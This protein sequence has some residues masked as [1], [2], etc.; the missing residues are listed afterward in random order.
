VAEAKC[1]NC[2]RDLQVTSQNSLLRTYDAIVTWN[3]LVGG[4][5]CLTAPRAVLSEINKKLEKWRRQGPFKREPLSRR[6]HSA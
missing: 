6:T 2:L 1:P 4:P 5:R 3:P